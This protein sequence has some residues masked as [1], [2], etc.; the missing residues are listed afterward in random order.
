MQLQ[1]SSK[2]GYIC[3]NF[4]SFC[5]RENSQTHTVEKGLIHLYAINFS[6]L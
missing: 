5:N 1:P 2:I 3:M 6:E 4:Q